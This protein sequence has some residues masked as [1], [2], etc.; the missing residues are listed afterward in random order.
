MCNHYSKLLAASLSLLMAWPSLLMASAIL[1]LAP[2]VIHPALAAPQDG[3]V[4][5]GQGGISQNGKTTTIEQ[6]SNRLS[7]NWQSFGIAADETV[8]FRQPSAS[9]IALNRVIGNDPSRIYGQLNA[10]GRVYLINPNGIL[11]GS[12]AQ[13]NVGGLVAS[14]LDVVDDSLGSN[15]RRFVGNS[16]ASVVAVSYTHLTL[17]TKA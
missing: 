15:R 8:Q 12:G 1:W 2:A 4:T 5:S 17:P 10:N 7:I 6:S 3:R 9:A 16:K 14:T 11:F 13:V